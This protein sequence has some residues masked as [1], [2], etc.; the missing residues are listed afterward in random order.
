MKMILATA[1]IT[2]F[3]L[4]CSKDKLESKPRLE[5]GDYNR[6]VDS[7]GVMTIRINFFDKEG[8]L[9][10]TSF[11]AIKNRLNQFPPATNLGDT[12]RLTTPAFPAKDEGEISFSL[13]YTRLD[14]DLRTNDTIRFK[15]AVTDKKGN[16]SDTI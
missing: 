12:F 13:D 2:I 7:P 15:F 8:D 16:M 5:F 3:L 14:E 4:A 6:T 10:E 1:I 9:D 11:T